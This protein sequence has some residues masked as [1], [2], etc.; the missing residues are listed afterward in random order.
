MF[1]RGLKRDAAPA[2]DRVAPHATVP[3]F[4]TVCP[5]VCPS[6]AVRATIQLC[7]CVNVTTCTCIKAQKRVLD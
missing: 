3:A 4:A 1:R 6:V 5:S 7:T 2:A